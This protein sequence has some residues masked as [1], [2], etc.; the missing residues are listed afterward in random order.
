MDRDDVV[1]YLQ[2]AGVGTLG[3]GSEEGGYAVPMSFGY[4]A[5]NE[6]CIFQFAFD[7]RSEKLSYIEADSPVTLAVHDR[8]SVDD[9]RSVLVRG[10]LEEVPS[11]ERTRASAVF[12]SQARMASTDVFEKPMREID[13]EWYR[14]DVE[15]I[16]GRR[17]V[18]KG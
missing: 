13:F 18:V 2:E 10:P 11:D 5:P 12:A 9:W 7:D 17:A 14:I 15:E 3:F 6:D 16:T 1:D 8:E 4:D